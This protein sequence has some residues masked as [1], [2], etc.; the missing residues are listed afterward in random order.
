MQAGQELEI[1]LTALG[2]LTTPEQFGNVV[3]KTVAGSGNGSYAA[4]VRLRDVAR[5]ELGAQ[6]YD[7]RCG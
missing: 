7:Q 6:S 1:P 2:R 5:V 4:M 3:V